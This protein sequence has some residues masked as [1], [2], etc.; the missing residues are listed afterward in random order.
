MAEGFFYNWGIIFIYKMLQL[1]LELSL[2]RRIPAKHTDQIYFVLIPIYTHKT[3][4]AEL[5]QIIQIF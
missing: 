3:A 1:R 2:H 4:I 5:I